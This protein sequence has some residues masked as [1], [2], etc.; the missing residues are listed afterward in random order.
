MK[1][2]SNNS[3]LKEQEKIIERKKN[4]I[5]LTSLLDPPVQKGGNKM[6]K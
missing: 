4:E 3:Q 1:K 6:L 2:Q 5:D